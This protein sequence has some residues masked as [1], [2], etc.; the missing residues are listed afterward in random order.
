MA[1]SSSKCGAPRFA[2][3]EMPPQGNLQGVAMSVAMGL[4]S[5]VFQ[6]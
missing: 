2:I 3:A 4:F 1:E 5:T 6:Q